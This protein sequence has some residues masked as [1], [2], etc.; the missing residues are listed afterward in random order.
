[1]EYNTN[2]NDCAWQYDP[3]NTVHRYVAPTAL[4]NASGVD[5]ANAMSLTGFKTYHKSIT[6]P[7]H[8]HLAAGGYSIPYKG[9]ILLTS[10]VQPVPFIRIEGAGETLTELFGNYTSGGPRNSYFYTII[11]VQRPT[12]VI[13][14]LKI[15]N[16]DDPIFS[17]GVDRFRL[18][19][20]T[21]DTAA[22]PIHLPKDVTESADTWIMS[23]VTVRNYHS[24][25]LRMGGALTKNLRI[26]NS[27]FDA[28]TAVPHDCWIGGIQIFGP[29]SNIEITNGSTKNNIGNCAAGTYQQGDGVEMDN[30]NF[31]ESAEGHPRDVRITGLVVENNGDGGLDLKASNVRVENVSLTNSGHYHLRNWFFGAYRHKNITFAGTGGKIQIMGANTIWEDPTTVPLA[32]EVR[33]EPNFGHNPGARG[34]FLENPDLTLTTIKACP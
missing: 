2:F 26:V 1:M 31:P 22:R 12:V 14:N 11:H 13:Q 16:A 9:T 4:G 23:S 15:R 18:M 10:D 3:P 8:F 25:G 19:N 6:A 20:V 33:C 32:S 34:V 24:F 5:P 7:H 28:G 21:I 30:A 29:M 17:W 27:N